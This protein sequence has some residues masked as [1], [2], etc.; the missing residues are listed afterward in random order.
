MEFAISHA[1]HVLAVMAQIIVIRATL[2]LSTG[3]RLVQ[4]ANVR[5]VIMMTE[6]QQPVNSVITL[7]SLAW[8]LIATNALVA[9][10]V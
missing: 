4:F 7:A 3:K 8:G 6:F 9:E 1:K 2:Q 10:R 5:M